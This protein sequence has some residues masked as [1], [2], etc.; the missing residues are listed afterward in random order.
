M[1]GIHSIKQHGDEQQG[2]QHNRPNLCSIDTHLELELKHDGNKTN[3]ANQV[4]IAVGD[5]EQ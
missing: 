1:T 4:S 3:Y 5:Q 2:P